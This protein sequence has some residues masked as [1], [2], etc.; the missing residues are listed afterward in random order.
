MISNLKRKSTSLILILTALFILPL[1]CLARVFFLPGI[2]YTDEFGIVGNLAVILQ[3]ERRDRFES[4]LEYFG[5]DEGQVMLSVFMP[6]KSIEWTF[7]SR[8]QIS[9]RKSFSPWHASNNDT[10]CEDVQ[11]WTDIWGRVD[12]MKESGLFYGLQG[13]YKRYRFKGEPEWNNVTGF[14]PVVASIYGEGEEY[15]GSFRVGLE[16]RDNRYNTHKGVHVLWQIDIGNV[17]FGQKQEGVIRTQVDI[18]KYFPLTKD[19][20]TLAFNLR[21]GAI[22]SHVPY[23]SQFKLGGSQSLRGFPVDRYH[24]NAYYLLRAEFRQ[25]L[26]TDLPSP[27]KWLKKDDPNSADD[28]FSTGFILFTDL[29]DLWRDD[30]SWWGLRQNIGVG[31][32]TIF[33]PDVVASICV[34]TPTD[35]DHLAFHLDLKQSF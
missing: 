8:Y 32:I 10:Q 21:G 15:T 14:D 16:M 9:G 5:A 24:G 17:Y 28:T 4:R 13:V 19:K 35:S 11:Y 26:Q 1:T 34:A 29:G 22:H 2:Y 23:I 25:I 27:F 7:E 6:R 30:H 3:T 12:F 33:P 31:L 18:R 20:T